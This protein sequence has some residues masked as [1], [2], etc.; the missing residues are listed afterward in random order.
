[1][2]LNKE[3]KRNETKVN[4]CLGAHYFQ[5]MIFKY[6]NLNLGIFFRMHFLSKRTSYLIMILDEFNKSH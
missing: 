2:P 6:N 4:H 3:T 1:M 5:N